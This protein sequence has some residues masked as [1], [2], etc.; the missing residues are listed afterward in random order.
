M[1]FCCKYITKPIIRGR[2]FKGVI[3]SDKSKDTVVV[4]WDYFNF[5]PKY[6]RYQRK[7]TKILVH[8]PSCIGAKKGDIVTI[9][10]C[11]PISKKKSFVIVEKGESK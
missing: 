4:Q 3:V 9:A 2:I 8:N 5:I 7:N 11:R 1:S 10:E 6:E